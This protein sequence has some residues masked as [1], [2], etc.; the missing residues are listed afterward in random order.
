MSKTSGSQAAFDPSEPLDPSRALTPTAI[1]VNE[2][3]VNE[4]FWPKFRKVATRIPFAADV[5]SLYFAARDPLTPMASKGMM[6]AGLAYFILPADAIPDIIPGLG[7]TDDAAVIGALIALL[8]R[9]LKPH[10]KQAALG[11]LSRFGG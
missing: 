5:L 9:T 3:R 11:L 6:L 7:F 8:G 4:G 2:W 1:R 10:H